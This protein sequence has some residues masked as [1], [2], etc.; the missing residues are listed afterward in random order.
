MGLKNSFGGKAVL[1]LHCL[2]WKY[3]LNEDRELF[4]RLYRLYEEKDFGTFKKEEKSTLPYHLFDSIICL[5]EVAKDYLVNIH[6]VDSGK[7]NII[8]N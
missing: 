6:Q 5:S 3:K 2:P 1:H 4:N 8:H 7:I